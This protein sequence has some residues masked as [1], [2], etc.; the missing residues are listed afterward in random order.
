MLLIPKSKTTPGQSKLLLGST[1]ANW[2][3]QQPCWIN[4]PRTSQLLPISTHRNFTNIDPIHET[5]EAT[6]FVRAL[7]MVGF[8][9]S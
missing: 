7:A 3:V 2:R 9:L 1:H 5:I 8:G 6:G 4:N